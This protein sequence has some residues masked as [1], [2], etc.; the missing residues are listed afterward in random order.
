MGGG[1]GMRKEAPAARQLQVLSTEEPMTLLVMLLAVDTYA[2]P[3]ARIDP[4]PLSTVA[5]HD[6]NLVIGAAEIDGRAQA[7]MWSPYYGLVSV[8]RQLR[9]RG[10]DP[11]QLDAVLGAAVSGLSCSVICRSGDM[12][13]IAWIDTPTMIPMRSADLDGDGDVDQTD[14]GLLQRC[15]SG[16][17]VFPDDGCEYADLDSDGDVD[18]EDVG[19]IAGLLGCSTVRLLD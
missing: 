3:L 11:P 5:Y 15:L 8:E 16:P 10:V 13:Y 1:R 12:L 14:F 9:A 19:V 17:G 7:A 2:G 6:V 4:I 18:R